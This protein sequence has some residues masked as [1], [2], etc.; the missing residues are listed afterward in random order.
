MFSIQVQSNESDK[1]KR[2]CFIKG[3]QKSRKKSN[4]KCVSFFKSQ[5]SNSND[6]NKVNHQKNKHKSVSPAH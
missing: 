6:T 1:L 5:P 3:K 2:K 4:K